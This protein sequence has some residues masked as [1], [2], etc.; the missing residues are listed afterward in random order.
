MFVSIYAGTRCEFILSYRGMKPC[1]SEL[2]D[3]WLTT[4]IIVN[5]RVPIYK[6]RVHM[7]N[8]R[9]FSR[10]SHLP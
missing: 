9:Y 8:I 4:T 3:R 7:N 5:L 10:W 6:T 2:E 1:L